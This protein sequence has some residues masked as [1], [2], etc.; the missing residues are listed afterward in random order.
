LPNKDEGLGITAI[1][2][3]YSRNLPYATDTKKRRRFGDVFPLLAV[4]LPSFTPCPRLRGLQNIAGYSRI[5]KISRSQ[6]RKAQARGTNG[7]SRWLANVLI[8]KFP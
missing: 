6:R 4:V 1:N 5:P 8:V 3:R 7:P 2:E